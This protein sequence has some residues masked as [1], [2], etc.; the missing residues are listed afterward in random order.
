MYPDPQMTPG[1]LCSHADSY[2]YP[3][4]VAYCDRS[5]SKQTKWA[6]IET[7][8]RTFHFQID[9]SDRSQ[10]KIDHKIPLCVGGSNEVSNLWPQHQSIYK[11]T[12]PLEGLACEKMAAGRLKQ[13]RAVELLNQAK[14]NLSQAP[15]VLAILNGL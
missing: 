9:A 10:F 11:I 4:H 15:Q 14:M 6:V 12:D 2:R 13:N 3:E 7:Y 5:V 8:N 1:S